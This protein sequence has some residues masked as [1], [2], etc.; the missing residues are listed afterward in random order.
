MMIKL[1]LKHQLLELAL[2]NIF[3]DL[4]I[5]FDTD[6]TVSA[7]RIVDKWIVDNKHRGAGV[8]SYAYH[9][10]YP[11]MMYDKNTRQGKQLHISKIST[12]YLD[13]MAEYLRSLPESNA[14]F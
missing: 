9:P 1:F 11:Y 4:M 13:E 12:S 3:T 5:K 8:Y 7:K 10:E 2:D 14:P 6:I